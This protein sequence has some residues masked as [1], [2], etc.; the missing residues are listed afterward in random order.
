MDG[1]DV[2]YWLILAEL[3]EDHPIYE[4]LK[5]ILKNYI[6]HR[7]IGLKFVRGIRASRVFWG[8]LQVSC[9]GPTIVDNKIIKS[10]RRHSRKIISYADDSVIGEGGDSRSALQN[11]ANANINHCICL[12]L[13]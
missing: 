9:L 8:C 13:L 2:M 10:Y 11:T 7:L 5:V 6:N 3:I 4:H 1:F 12:C